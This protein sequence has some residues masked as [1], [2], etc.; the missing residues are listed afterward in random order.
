LILQVIRLPHCSQITFNGDFGLDLRRKACRM[1]K[2]IVISGQ[3]VSRQPRSTE[4]IALWMLLHAA[5]S[6]KPPR[7]EIPSL[8]I[9]VTRDQ[10]N[11]FQALAPKSAFLPL[12]GSINQSAQSSPELFRPD[13]I[14]Q[15]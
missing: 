14:F 4:F 7:T 11:F 5:L 9:G 12:G 10:L 1:S 3:Q 2:S 8:E 15:N 6:S 13:E